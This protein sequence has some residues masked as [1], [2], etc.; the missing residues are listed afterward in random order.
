MVYSPIEA[1]AEGLAESPA[2]A[3]QSLDAIFAA[4]AHRGRREIVRYLATRST[5]PRMN[6]VAADNGL[7]PQLL[8]KHAATLEKAGLASRVTRGRHSH[9]VL[10]ADALGAAER[11][12][13]QTRAF[14]D[15]QLDSLEAYVAELAGGGAGNRAGEA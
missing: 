10:D 8:N 6:E 9:L 13:R 1:P 4:L 11:W 2:D 15:Q 5:A 7:S 3:A 14:W 12:V